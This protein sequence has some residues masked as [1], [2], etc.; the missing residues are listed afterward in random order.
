MMPSYIGVSDF[1]IFFILPAYSKKASSPTKMGEI[2]N[3]GIPIICNSGVGD[4]DEIMGNILPKLLVNDFNNKE[5]NRVIDFILN[6]FKLD[7]KK[8]IQISHNYYSL[9]KGVNKYLDIYNKILN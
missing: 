4:V 3:L 8:I 1:S 5:Y 9:N 7:S 6:E 2:M